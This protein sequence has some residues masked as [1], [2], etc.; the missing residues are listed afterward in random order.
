MS[1]AG[2]R[3]AAFTHLSFLRTCRLLRSVTASPCDGP[4]RG[5]PASNHR[6]LR[7][8]GGVGLVLRRPT[9]GRSPRSDSAMGPD[10]AILLSA[11]SVAH[12][13]ANPDAS[14]IARW[15]RRHLR[16]MD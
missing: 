3:L 8:A 5:D 2:Q 10:S 11:S 12:S 1:Q 16:L 15:Y 14:A 4:L 13:A 6:R 7:S 9:G